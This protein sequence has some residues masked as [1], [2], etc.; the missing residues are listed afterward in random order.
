VPLSIRRDA[1][2]NPILNANKEPIIEDAAG[3]E[4]D[5]NDIDIDRLLSFLGTPE[6]M[7]IPI[8]A[9]DLR[10]FRKRWRNR[11]NFMGPQFLMQ[12][13]QLLN[14]YLNSQNML[15][16]TLI[17]ADHK[18]ETNEKSK[19][20]LIGRN[21]MAERKAGFSFWKWLFEHRGRSASSDLFHSIG[22]RIHLGG[23]GRKHEG[24][25][26]GAN[27]RIVETFNK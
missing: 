8:N 22:R 1:A 24:E 21:V 27:K 9:G 13:M 3:T 19:L 16:K 6:A 20:S 12:E 15:H 25:Q 14:Q 5:Y 2:G 11:H 7:T 17:P 23:G 26:I 4:Y 10:T 18:L